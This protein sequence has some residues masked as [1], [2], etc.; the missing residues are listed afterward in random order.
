MLPSVPAT[1]KQSSGKGCSPFSNA[2]TVQMQHSFTAP[3]LPPKPAA[4]V[5]LSKIRYMIVT[6]QPFHS[7]TILHLELQSLILSWTGKA[8]ASLSRE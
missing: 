5:V 7:L 8:N 4:E 3:S 1:G 6:A 2:V